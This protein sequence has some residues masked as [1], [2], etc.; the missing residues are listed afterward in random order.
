MENIFQI[1]WTTG[2]FFYHY[3]LLCKQNDNLLIGL[4]SQYFLPENVRNCSKLEH[5]QTLLLL[6]LTKA[7]HLQYLLFSHQLKYSS[8][9]IKFNILNPQKYI[10]NI[11]I[12][13]NGH[14]HLR[15]EWDLNSSISRILCE[16]GGC[17]KHPINHFDV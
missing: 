1:L 17:K 15:L 6:S 14:N 12:Y 4:Y 5:L 3:F 10:Y 7:I 8:L 11:M 9:S 2:M 13:F 16:V